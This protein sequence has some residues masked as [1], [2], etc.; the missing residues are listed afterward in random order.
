MCDIITVN[1][2]HSSYRYLLQPGQIFFFLHF[3]TN[4]WNDALS[5]RLDSLSPTLM[6]SV[7]S[8]SAFSSLS[9]CPARCHIRSPPPSGY[10]Y[11][12]L[13]PTTDSFYRSHRITSQWL[14][15]SYRS[16]CHESHCSL[17]ARQN[18]NMT[19]SSLF[20]VF[21]MPLVGLSHS[22]NMYMSSELF[23]MLAKSIT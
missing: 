18:S 20:N 13:Q 17:W 5:A 21:S 1:A 9:T 7:R 6:S 12:A 10:K 2:S 22:G 4:I 8:V 3:N 11:S 19:L 15:S 16:H 23:I 14:M